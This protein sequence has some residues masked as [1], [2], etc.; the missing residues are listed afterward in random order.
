MI[1]G[2][3]AAIFDM[4]G[5]ILDSMYYWRLS[6]L[7]YILAHKLPLNDELLSGIFKRGAGM[8]VKMSYELAG[9]S[10]YEK[11]LPEISKKLVGY[12]HSHYQSDVHPKPYAIAFLE[13]LKSEG[14]RCCVATATDKKYASEALKVHGMD[15]YFEF[16]FDESDAGCNKSHIR[17]FEKVVEKLGCDK[18]DCVMF[19]D[20]VYSIK[21]AKKFGMRVVG[22]EDSYTVEG[23]EAVKSL[24]DQ[25]IVD[26]SELL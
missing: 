4:D 5:T 25:Y 18:A 24:V 2:Y 10:T 21:T 6:S 16:I 1:S 19:E 20:A 3:K 8:T 11:D 22:I 15:K 26:Y 9:K 13:K 14:V 12:V 17:F 7:E 23:P